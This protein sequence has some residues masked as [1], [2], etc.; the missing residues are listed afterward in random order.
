M[1]LDSP[2]PKKK[3]K[4]NNHNAQP[5]QTNPPADDKLPHER[6]ISL[7]KG[8]HI[9]NPGWTA[10]TPK[11]PYIP[12]CPPAF[13]NQAQGKR[14]SLDSSTLLCY[15]TLGNN[16][17]LP[18]DGP[19]VIVELVGATND[20]N[21]VFNQIHNPHYG[22]TQTGNE[23][24]QPPTIP[25]PYTTMHF[26]KL[27]PS[28]VT[29]FGNLHKTM[30]KQVQSHPKQ[31]VTIIP[32]EAGPHLTQDNPKMSRDI[33]SFL[34]SLGFPGSNHLQVACPTPNIVPKTQAH[35]AKPFPYLLLN[36]PEALHCLLLWQ[37]TFTFQIS[38]K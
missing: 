12:Y 25:I 4:D 9:L 37:Q 16:A 10:V 14:V 28:Y 31:Y 5:H 21:N 19:T 38:N 22:T 1:E 27:A 34:K 20:M 11:K 3:A 8:V 30:V 23:P 2:R 17:S 35:F 36:L 15:T 18:H 7:P 29:L 32:F 24:E 13:Q 6:P 33:E 26:P